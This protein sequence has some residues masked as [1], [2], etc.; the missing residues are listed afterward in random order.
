MDKE[1]LRTK[2]RMKT[3]TNKVVEE[4]AKLLGISEVSI[5]AKTNGRR[6]FRPSEIE[7]IRK[8]YNLSNDDVVTIF[9]EGEK[10]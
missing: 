6:E 10:R 7:T 5:V 9:I 2:V 1:L 4:L 8:E 3:G